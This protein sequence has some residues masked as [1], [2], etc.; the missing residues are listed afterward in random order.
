MTAHVPN[1]EHTPYISCKNRM[2]HYYMSVCSVLQRASGGVLSLCIV[3]MLFVDEHFR[4]V[5]RPV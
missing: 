3:E 5:R 2:P 4:L 1:W